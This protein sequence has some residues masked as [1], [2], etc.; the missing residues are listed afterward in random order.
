[1]LQLEGERSLEKRKDG[2]RGQMLV[3]GAKEGKSKRDVGE[4]KKGESEAK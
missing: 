3:L 4:I 1:M 2:M